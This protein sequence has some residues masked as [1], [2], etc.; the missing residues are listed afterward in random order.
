MLKKAESL[1][2]LLALAQFGGESGLEGD[3]LEEGTEEEKQ[4]DWEEDQGPDEGN[5][6][7]EGDFV[8]HNIKVIC[9][10]KVGWLSM[11]NH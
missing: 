2:L 7:K 4:K 3:D 8:K 1:A 9:G 10:N 5:L 6:L 11:H